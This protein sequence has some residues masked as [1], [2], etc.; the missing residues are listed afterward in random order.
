MNAEGYERAN[1]EGGF[2]GAGIDI[3]EYESS[4]YDGMEE[5]CQGTT[6]IV[7]IG[8]VGGEGSDV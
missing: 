1:E 3:I 4:V 8:R 7:F 6:G 5:S 2:E